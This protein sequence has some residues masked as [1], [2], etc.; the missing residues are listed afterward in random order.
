MLKKY[1]VLLAILLALSG[2]SKARAEE[3][4]PVSKS[5]T[6][7]VLVTQTFSADIKPTTVQKEEV[8][9]L[10]GFLI[11]QGL[12]K[13]DTPPT[14]NFGPKTKQ[15][16][17][18]LQVQ[19]D[20]KPTGTLGP[21]TRGKLNEI[22]L[23]P[24]KS[25]DAGSLTPPT[26]VLPP[27]TT[28]PTS[29]IT[30]PTQLPNTVPTNSQPEKIVVLTKGDVGIAIPNPNIPRVMF[31]QG[32]VN[33]HINMKTGA[34]ETDPDG[35][36]SF[37]G[38]EVDHLT[39]C[40][41]FYPESISVVP[42]M[43][44]TIN[45]WHNR[46]N[47]DNYTST[48]LSYRCVQSDDKVV[49]VEP[50]TKESTTT[51]IPTPTNLGG[52]V[53]RV[54]F[55]QGKVNQHTDPITGAWMTDPDGLQS[56]AGAEVDHLTY[57]KMFYPKS[58]AVVPYAYEKIDSWHNRGNV[59]NYT[60]TNLS[61]RC[62]QDGEDVSVRDEQVLGAFTSASA[63]AKTSFKSYM[64][65]GS[66]GDEVTKLQ[67]L[68]KQKG[69]LQSDATGFFGKQTEDAV[70]KFQKD[71]GIEE[72]GT[73]GQYTRA[74]L[75]AVDKGEIALGSG[76]T[77][78]TSPK[79]GNG[80]GN[81]TDSL[82]SGSTVPSVHVISP[83]GGEVYTNQQQV[84]VNW[85]RC[86]F[87]SSTVNI[88]LAYYLNGGVAITNASTVLQSG[89]TANDGVE[90]VTLDK[91]LLGLQGTDG[92][93]MFYKIFVTDGGSPFTATIED[94]SDNLFTI[95]QGASTTTPILSVVKN[96]TFNDQII[97]TGNGVQI[98]SYV[99]TNLS[100]TD[101]VKLTNIQIGLTVGGG[102]AYTNF[103]NLYYHGLGNNN[104]S[105][106]MNPGMINS[107]P[108][109]AQNTV[110]PPGGSTTVD[111]YANVS[112]MAG[113]IK[114]D[115]WFT[116]LD[117]T[118][119]ICSPSMT[120]NGPGCIGYPQ[121]GQTMTLGGG[122]GTKLVA[123]NLATPI[124]N[125]FV[126]TTAGVELANIELNTGI[127]NENVKVN[128]ITMT[129]TLGGPGAYA[130][131]ANLVMKNASGTVLA[132]T[133][134]TAVNANR[135][136][137]TLINPIIIPNNSAAVVKLYADVVGGAN[138]G[139]HKFAV[140]NSTDII[141]VGVNSGFTV[142]VTVYGSGQTMTIRTNGMLSVSNV[143]GNGGTPAMAQVV[144]TGT[145]DG[146]YLAYKWNAFYESQKIR[147]IVLKA[148]GSQL[149][150][151]D[152]SNLR[153]YAQQGSGPLLGTT[154]PFATANQFGTCVSN[155]CQFSWLTVDNLLPFTVN[156][157]IGVTIFVKAD[158]TSAPLPYL[159]DNFY[160]SV[161]NNGTD[162]TGFGVSSG[163]APTYDNNTANAFGAPSQIVP[164]R[165]AVTGDYPTS[166]STI[167]SSV[168]A[169]TH[170]GRFKVMNNGTSA[171]TLTNAKFSDSGSHTGTSARYT[172]Y[173]SG[174]NMSN[175]TANTLGVSAT[176]FSAG[177][178]TMPISITLN[179]G[180]YRY[181]TVAITNVAG[182]AS[183]DTFNLSFAQMGDL[184][185]SLSEA[186]WA[187]DGNQD[188][189]TLDTSSNLWTDGRPSLGFVQ[190]Q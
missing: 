51:A 53:P 56:F 154:M 182:I 8:K 151:N 44:E 119:T 25:P 168:P 69:Y 106:M 48:L 34:W 79:G 118:I 70:K 1:L 97:G 159:G 169:G 52:T 104:G 75:N 147:K 84:S 39:Y 12:L 90:V 142:P 92:D 130:D 110:I 143:A 23:A 183:G 157:G 29:G 167:V 49:S 58:V 146:I 128:S 3:N 122:S 129:D 7:S 170:I 150:Q 94:S 5:D 6:D 73:C 81:G 105:V 77:A 134:S 185:F 91:G 96:N 74:K 107:F 138:G 71:N 166:G 164:F 46:G 66:R 89:S 10:Q 175:Y 114:T 31:W 15:A 14:G 179:P 187:H 16:V 37:A 98:G 83:N 165:V 18:D 9:K 102:A 54:M 140:I 155:V 116:A 178:L 42:Y 112:G 141:A 115:L 28:P 30:P 162:V 65:N 148:S 27:I 125:S 22:I 59:Q 158:I 121:Y 4:A 2:V 109:L 67:Q 60:S 93:G 38:A 32:K 135:V 100:T 50:T 136:T 61:Y 171:V 139:T 177:S 87:T 111:I 103:H 163:L 132:T 131:I 161:A 20:I 40:K 72:T 68:L 152:I 181:I 88:I 189:D 133:S 172:V 99:V 80:G 21:I 145:V 120:G 17:K 41:M 36:Q 45:S 85:S 180:A 184:K 149:H 86:N 153:L 123:T 76:T 57:C 176:D 124:S 173:A 26:E 11:N 63:V 144:P 127:S 113:T 62:V 117:G 55:W 126:P 13:I 186:T 35:L 188:G 137:F 108:A 190:K 19:L 174:E 156:P 24:T 95:H 33:Q 82:C 47:V 43:Y 101:T 64:V 160:M 78:G